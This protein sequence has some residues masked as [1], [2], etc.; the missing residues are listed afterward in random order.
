MESMIK[1]PDDMFRQELLPYLTVHDIAK[2]DSACMNIRYR[3]QLLFK[4]SGVILTGEKKKIMKPLLFK[5]L[6]MR[7]IY[8]T[9]MIIAVS[10]IDSNHSISMNDYV[11]QFRHTQH[12]E[13]RG[14]IRDDMSIFIISHCSCLLSI[15]IGD[16]YSYLHP[17]I[18]D[19]TL[20]SI[21][22]HCTGLQSLSLSYC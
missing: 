2:L 6:G 1:L 22:E 3:P 19:L 9:K 20:H 7:R 17:K 4:I 10:D 16:C 18:S 12:V 13:M 14:P 5:W 21:A 15:D 11:D 8:F